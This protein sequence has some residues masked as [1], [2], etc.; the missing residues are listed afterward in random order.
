MKTPQQ[1][2]CRYCGRKLSR[3]IGGRIGTYDDEYGKVHL[4]C[5]KRIRGNEN[6]K[7]EVVPME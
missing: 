4:A 3:K 7:K 6:D 5:A 2:Y 1:I